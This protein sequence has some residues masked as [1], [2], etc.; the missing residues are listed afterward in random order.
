VQAA[1]Q[2]QQQQQHHQQQQQQQHAAVAAA[3][4]AVMNALPA[5]GVPTVS[6]SQAGGLE[7]TSPADLQPL[8]LLAGLQS[9]LSQQG[10]LQPQLSQ[11]QQLQTAVPPQQQPPPPSGTAPV[12]L[13][14]T[15]NPSAVAAAA[16][17]ANLQSHLHAVLAA[18]SAAPLS[19]TPPNNHLMAGMPVST[20]SLPTGALPGVGG[21]LPGNMLLPP[22][23]P[24]ALAGAP[25]PPA[26][27]TTAA[28]VGPVHRV[29]SSLGLAAMYSGEWAM[30]GKDGA[31]QGGV[32]VP[33]SAGDGMPPQPP[34]PPP[35]P[36]LQPQASGGGV[37]PKGGATGGNGLHQGQPQLY[38]TTQG[39][40][41][42]PGDA[43]GL[44]AANHAAMLNHAMGMDAATAAAA[45]AAAQ[46]M[47][48]SMNP[49][50]VAAAAA[51]AA[52]DGSYLY[53]YGR[54]GMGPGQGVPGGT[55]PGQSAPMQYTGGYVPADVMHWSMWPNGGQP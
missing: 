28:A 7:G 46:Q 15:A 37:G 33:P 3:A 35:P 32:S 41:G 11:Q 12:P 4:A 48:S 19:G 38:L 6:T 9:Q 50:A 8:Q 23:P 27:P 54:G 5:A 18:V 45:A 36:A 47:V 21:A 1:M 14:S 52:A 29:P 25:P 10:A 44:T 16:A 53:G 2:Q 51:A 55:M 30:G 42:L 39:S 26:A 22:L 49:A 17:A 13:P 43:A 40:Y 20:Y 34:P 31:G 24:G